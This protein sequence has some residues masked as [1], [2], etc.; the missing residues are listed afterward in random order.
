MVATST[1]PGLE[2]RT[3]INSWTNYFYSTIVC[4]EQILSYRSKGICRELKRQRLQ[5]NPNFRAG[6]GNTWYYSVLKGFIR[7]LRR[8]NLKTYERR[9]RISYPVLF[10]IKYT[11]HHSA[12]IV[13]PTI[14]SMSPSALRTRRSLES[15]KVDWDKKGRTDKVLPLTYRL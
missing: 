15:T 7:K 14:V 1:E 11:K 10:N 6:K 4:E 13:L 5:L 9:L 12:C 8:D 2:P 3:K